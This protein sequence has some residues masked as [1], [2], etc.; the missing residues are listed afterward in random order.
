[1]GGLMLGLVSPS[2]LKIILGVVL[3]ASAARMFS[4]SKREK[5]LPDSA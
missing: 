1:M 2:L 5:A 4:H 3:I